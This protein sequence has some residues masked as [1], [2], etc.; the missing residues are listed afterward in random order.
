MSTTVIS[1]WPSN[2]SNKDSNEPAPQRLG[3]FILV[4]LAIHALL[5]FGGYL[6]GGIFGGPGPGGGDSVTFQLAAGPAQDRRA[7]P[8]APK[9]IAEPVKP[10]P[11]AKP[12]PKPEVAVR[13]SKKPIEPPKEEVK[14]EAVEET[15]PQTATAGGGLEGGTGGGAGGDAAE[16]ILNRKG[17][18]MTGGQI[19]SRISGKTF[20]LEM[21]RV[22][23]EGGNR[24]INTVIQLNPDGS[25]K[26]TLTHYFAQTYHGQYSSTRSESGSGQWMIEG[27]KW[28]HRSKIIQ[29]NTKD[30]YDI[31]SDGPT[32]RLYYA[33]CGM[34]SS[35]YC[36]TGRLAAIGEVR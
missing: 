25:S 27:N 4:S 28:C 14:P 8:P 22:D 26:V 11:V 5:Y 6:E 35:T 21:G 29:Y 20:H 7:A 19:L 24:L 32:L 31:T 10:K 9:K 3:L 34:E 17:N 15:P 16:T 13:K 23:L 33:D 2:P 1:G 12:E 36:Q 18:A 30:C